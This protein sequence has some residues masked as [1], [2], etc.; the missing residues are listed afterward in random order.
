MS[1]EQIESMVRASNVHAP[2][3]ADVMLGEYGTLNKT[4]VDDLGR[5]LVQAGF[6]VR[7]LHLLTSPVPLPPEPASR[8]DL[9]VLGIEGVELVAVPVAPGP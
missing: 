3:W 5:A 9:S 4:G 8:L 7:R 6:V 1:D 2:D